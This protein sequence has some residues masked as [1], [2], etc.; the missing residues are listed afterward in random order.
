MSLASKIRNSWKLLQGRGVEITPATWEHKYESGH[1]DYLRSLDQYPRYCVLAGYARSFARSPAVLDIGCGSGVLERAL[2]GHYSEYVGIDLSEN[3]VSK[4]A[5]GAGPH[6]SFVCADALIW[7]PTRR[8]DA[9]VSNEV[10]YYF[11]DP[12][13]VL[14]RYEKYLNSKGAF[15]IR[16]AV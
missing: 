15:M 7:E 3:A 13:S 2:S 5:K 14:R 6:A 12:A 4:A 1:W 9:I 8:I 10:L 16:G 11:Q